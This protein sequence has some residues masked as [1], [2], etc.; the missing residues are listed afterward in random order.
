MQGL[1]AVTIKALM[2]LTD[3]AVVLVETY[4]NRRMSLAQQAAPVSSS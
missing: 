4:S 3:L 2:V 1:Q